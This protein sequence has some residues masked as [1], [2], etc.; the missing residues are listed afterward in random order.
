MENVCDFCPIHSAPNRATL[1]AFGD[2]DDDGACWCSDDD[3]DDYPNYV[4]RG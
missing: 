3:E 1:H 2:D 4:L